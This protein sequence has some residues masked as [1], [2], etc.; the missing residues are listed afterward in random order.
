MNKRITQVRRGKN[1]HYRIRTTDENGTPLYKYK[2]LRF[3]IG[4]LLKKYEGEFV[5]EEVIDGIGFL[6]FSIK[7]IGWG[8]NPY[9]PLLVWNLCEGFYQELNE[10]FMLN[11]EA[12]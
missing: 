10:N 6:D 11:K 4:E 9:D 3:H 1:P 5:D 7:D 8:Q 12:K 2:E